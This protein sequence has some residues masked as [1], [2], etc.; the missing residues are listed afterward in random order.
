MIYQVARFNYVFILE[1]RLNIDLI[2]DAIPVPYVKLQ[3][4]FKK[5]KKI[6]SRS[7]IVPYRYKA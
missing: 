5:K 3:F 4:D 2:K 6:R 7:Q 1:I